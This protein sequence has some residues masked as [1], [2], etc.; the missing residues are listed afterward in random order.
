V[1]DP[2]FWN[3][4]LPFESI[5]SISVLEKKFKKEKKEL[6]K[7]E[8]LLKEFFKDLEIVYNDFMDAKFDT[9][10]TSASKKQ[11]E[12]DEEKLREILKKL[13][14]LNGIKLW[15]VEKSKEW[16]RDMLRTN[17]R[18]K[19]SQ[20]IKDMEGGEENNEAP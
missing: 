3:K 19:P 18:K 10:T 1:N 15:Y 8:K 5:I 14:K 9:R 12:S 4:V 20:F 2:D 16:L 7:N 17:K 11:L 13:I 6:G